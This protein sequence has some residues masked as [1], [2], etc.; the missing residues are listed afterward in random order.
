MYA[1]G[2]IVGI[3]L[4][5][6]DE[7]LQVTCEK[8][9][10]YRAKN[11]ADHQRLIGLYEQRDGL[12]SEIRQNNE[13]IMAERMVKGKGVYDNLRIT[14]INTHVLQFHELPLVNL[15]PISSA[16]SL[17]LISSK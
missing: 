6:T 4:A 7:F 2:T 17:L 13:L 5:G 12:K 11:R 10:E 16:K 3:A 9:G 8:Y 15:Y 14:D 1:A